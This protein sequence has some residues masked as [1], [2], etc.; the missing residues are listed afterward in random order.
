MGLEFKDGSKKTVKAGES[1]LVPPGHRPIMDKATVMIEF[2]QDPTWTK[3]MG[4]EAATA[5]PP[6]QAAPDEFVCQ[7]CEQEIGAPTKDLDKAK[8]HVPMPRV[9]PTLD[10][11]RCA[12]LCSLLLRGPRPRVHRCGSPRARGAK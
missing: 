1:Y 10:E 12:L 5:A 7:P 8:V 3:A 4:E 11:S 6:V 2:S 9:S